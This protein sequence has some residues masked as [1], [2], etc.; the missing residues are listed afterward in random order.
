MVAVLRAAHLAPSERADAFV[1]LVCESIVP[2]GDPVGVVVR[3]RDEVH[4]ADVGTLRIMT[5]GWTDGALA[6]GPKHLRRSDPE[7]CKIDVSFSGRFAVEQSDRQ[8]SLGAGSFS[9][10][11]LS[12]P[13][14]VAAQQCRLTAVM[15]P[16][17]LLP[18][19]ERDISE[20][21]GTTFDRTQPG[22]A[23]VTSVV[24]EMTD[25]LS[26]YE[27]ATGARLGAVVLDLIAVT[28]AGRVN[29]SHA[30]PV[31]LQRRALVLR[32]RAFIEENLHHPGLGPTAISASHHISR[33]FLHKLFEDQGTTVAG[34]IRARR[35]ERCRQD[36][37]DPGQAANPVSAIANRWG[38]RDPAYFNRVFRAEYGLP[39]A[40]YRRV[41]ADATQ[42]GT[43][44]R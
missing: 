42:L 31:E 25:N 24:R 5:L 28:L 3:A 2:Y 26:A 21:V 17:A 1:D 27:G 37:L 4:T 23:L 15:F 13:H 7:M 35:L 8:A 34:L 39:P 14:R 40:E 33:R 30:L 12:R 41:A 10:V 29:R 36:L 19:R 20:L 11:D 22:A 43:R 44:R 16:R 32:V 6:R 38:Y 9:L 18:L